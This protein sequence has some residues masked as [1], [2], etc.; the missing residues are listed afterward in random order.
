MIRLSSCLSAL[1]LAVAC[2]VVALLVYLL[3]Q[4]MIAEHDAREAEATASPA[5][6]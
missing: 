3:A 6:A 5:V 1:L 2:A 4:R